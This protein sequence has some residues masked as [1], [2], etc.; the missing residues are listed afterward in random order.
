[1]AGKLSN[2]FALVKASAGV[3]KSD[4]ELMFF[5]A[6]STW[7]STRSCSSSTRRWWEPL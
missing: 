7:S 5:P 3:L 4:K 6:R 2:S 1:M